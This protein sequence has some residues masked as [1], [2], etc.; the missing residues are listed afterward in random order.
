VA[1]LIYLTPLFPVA[2]EFAFFGIAPTGVSAIGIGI[3]LLGVG[4]VS[5]RRRR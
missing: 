2:I 4:L 3:T 1:S 5:W